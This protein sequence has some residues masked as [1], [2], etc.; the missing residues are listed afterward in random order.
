MYKRQVYA[1]SKNL[2]QGVKDL[3]SIKYAN[4]LKALESDEELASVV[5]AV[6]ILAGTSDNTTAVEDTT[7]DTED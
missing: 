5:K 7:E 1:N 6:R 4:V 2:P 3:I